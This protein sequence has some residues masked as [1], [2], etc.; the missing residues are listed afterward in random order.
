[1]DL[2][3]LLRHRLY[4]QGIAGAR[5]ATP[6]EVVGWMGAVQAQDYLGALW[7]IGLRMREAV[8]AGV[9]QALA[10]RT[11]VR[12]WP[13]RGTLHFVPGED[14]R[15]MLALL[16][17][18]VVAGNAR[19]YAELGLDD[20]T[21]AHS[22]EA[23]AKSLHGGKQLTR[24]EMGEVL[25]AAGVSTAGQRLYHILGRL[26]QEGTL[27]FGVRRGRQQTFVL[28]DEWLPPTRHLAREEALAELARRYFRSH[29]PAT[30]RDFAWWI[31]M[32]LG[33]ARLG[34]ELAGSELEPRECE[35]QTLW[36]SATMAHATEQPPSAWL[37]PAY[38]EYTV[39]YA[40]RSALLDTPGQAY[41]AAGHSILFPTVVIDGTVVGTWRR[42][43]G[44]QRID[45]ELNL[46][47]PLPA[48]EQQLVQ[49][50][51]DRYGVFFGLPAKVRYP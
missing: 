32:P 11:V 19:R 40:D 29:G 12:T 13:M 7:G 15:W 3:A 31:G 17:P 48:E 22:R 20:A 30:D 51:A 23:F 33:D 25:E 35:G 8:E 16:T 27:C 50:A 10:D 47:A 26:A 21:F 44:K 18:R 34:I 46:F 9:E 2:T 38:D 1:M 41:V 6:A 14:A 39:A 43:V 45:V 42:T 28:L 36:V 49:A 24:A 37:L 5:F 4:N